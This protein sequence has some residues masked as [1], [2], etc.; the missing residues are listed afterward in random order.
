VAIVA[1]YAYDSSGIRTRAGGSTTIDGGAPID[2]S[3]T[4]LIDGMNPTGYAQVLEEYTAAGLTKSYLLGDDVH[5]SFQPSYLLYDGHCSTRLLA[6][7]AG[8]ITDR[9]AYD[10]YGVMLGSSPSVLSP[11]TSD[12]G[13]CSEQF[14]SGLQ[15][16]YHRARYYDQSAGL[17]NRLDPFSGNHSDPQSL[18]KYAYCHA[19]PVNGIDPTG[20]FTLSELLISAK[21]HFTFQTLK[22]GAIVGGFTNSIFNLAWRLGTRKH[23]EITWE[24][25]L[26]DFGY[27]GLMGMLTGGMGAGAKAFFLAGGKKISWSIMLKIAVTGG[28]AKG[29]IST[30]LAYYRDLYFFGKNWSTEKF[31]SVMVSACL[32][33][34]VFDSLSGSIGLIAQRIKPVMERANYKVQQAISYRAGKNIPFRI[35]IKIDNWNREAGQAAFVIALNETLKNIEIVTLIEFAKEAAQ[36]FTSIEMEKAQ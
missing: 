1:T 23:D 12:L 19:D 7:S 9:K 15:M 30:V 6:D 32:F 17:W 13:F 36:S 11:Q 21:N 10:A 33:S 31:I 16:G 25:A 20:E 18:H 27:G 26:F 28:M 35:Q 29:I 8:T 24:N 22:T 2:N 34:V 3:R 5:F 14:D 4:F